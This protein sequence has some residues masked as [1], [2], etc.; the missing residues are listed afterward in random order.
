MG[1]IMAIGVAVANAILLVTF[2]ERDRI[3]GRRGIRWPPFPGAASRLRPILMTTCAMIGGMLPMA[4]GLGEGGDQTAPLGRAVIGG[5]SGGTIATLMI[6]PAI[7]AILQSGQTRKASL[8]IR[9]TA[10]DDQPGLAWAVAGRPRAK[11]RG[12]SRR[13]MKRGDVH[14]T[15]DVGRRLLA[16][17]LLQQR[18]TI[19]PAMFWRTRCRDRRGDFAQTVQTAVGGDQQRGE[20]SAGVCRSGDHSGVFCNRLSMPRISDMSP[21]VQADIGDHVSKNQLLAV[22]DDPELRQQLERAHAAVQQNRA[23]LE[24]SKRRLVGLQADLVLQQVTLRRKEQLSSRKA[25]SQ[26]H[27]DEQRGKEGVSRA[28]V[29]AGEADINL[30]E[31]NLEAAT[32]DQRRLEALLQYT[33][34]VA[35]YDGV[36]THRTINPGDL[37]QTGTANRP[38][39]PLFTCQ[40]IDKVRVFADVP[41]T[42]AAAIRP[43]WM[44]EVRLFGPDGQT[45]RGSV[46]RV[47]AALDPTTRTMRIEI[48]LPNPDE[49]LLPGMYAQV[50]LWP[51][52]GSADVH[53]VS[54]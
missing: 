17:V 31:A 6:L 45:V 11:R 20:R 41:E 42:N 32:A 21:K 29:E 12:R 22:I 10:R 46:T 47:S 9:P 4:I 1:A 50:S 51:S 3:D 30:A 19:F 15:S 2:A 39:A 54:R 37:V 48:D 43:G 44:A 34:I 26:Q 8:C 27:L 5:L 25:A 13:P 53:S 49:K 28:N 24:V 33:K 16:A 40:E 36:I 38:M 23:A 14:D 18:W 35:P 52:S 7:F